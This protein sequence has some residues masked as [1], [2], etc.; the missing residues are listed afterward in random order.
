MVILVISHSHV[1]LPEANAKS[2]GVSYWG[3]RKKWKSP[4][5]LA[6]TSHWNSQAPSTSA[7]AEVEVALIDRDDYITKYTGG[8]EGW[9][10]RNCFCTFHCAGAVFYDITD[11]GWHWYIW[12]LVCS[13]T[14]FI[15]IRRTNGASAVFMRV[16]LLPFSILFPCFTFFC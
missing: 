6:P 13:K 8:I 4:K 9:A 5:C 1:K 10:G 3:C 14:N 7:D 2:F 16:A 15:K 12:A 11:I